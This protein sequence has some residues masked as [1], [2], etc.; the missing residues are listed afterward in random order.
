MIEKKSQTLTEKL[1][2]IQTNLIAPKNQFN[3]FGGFKYRSCEDI[4]NAVKP[5][6]DETET[7]LIIH[8][9]VVL[10]GE[11]Y[12]IRAT[13]EISNGADKLAV[14][15]YAREPESR[16]GMDESQL[17]GATSSYARKYAM[18]GLFC[19]DDTKDA[20]HNNKGNG[21]YISEKELSFIRDGLAA[22]NATEESFLKYLQV[23]RLDHLPKS[24]Y[25][26]A[27]KA[28][29]ARRSKNENN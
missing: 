25:Q 23:D 2:Y 15:A 26:K 14:C 9:E 18:N 27:I 10:I 7:A 28:I 12:Y 1:R 8:D 19:I 5:L 11:R 24:D 4:L 3:K 21:E 22:V 17:T 20:D 6:L 16:K 13:A 29:E